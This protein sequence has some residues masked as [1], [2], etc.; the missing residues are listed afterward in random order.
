MS[1]K[2]GRG[3][4]LGRGLEGLLTVDVNDPSAEIR[5]IALRDIVRNE[6]QP[7][8][9]F[10]DDSLQ[11][12]AES[13]KEHGVLQPVLLRPFGQQFQLVAGERRWRASQLLG[14]DKIPALVREVSDREMAELS[15]IENLQRDDLNSVE[16]AMAYR[17]MLDDFGYTQETLAERLGKS[18]T[19]VS[20]TLRLLLL[21]KQVLDK[22]ADKQISASHARALLSI[23]DSTDQLRTAEA[24]AKDKIPVREV[25]LLLKKKRETRGRARRTKPELQSPELR[26]MEEELQNR[27][28]TKV[29]IWGKGVSGSIRIEYYSEED[30]ERLLELLGI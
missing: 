22:L 7:R 24:I 29:R 25:E 26:E 5:E 28:G 27:L 14:L 1:S 16:E 19:Y 3:K 23:K 2:G 9:V 8:K 10:D 17:R 6:E 21:P 11:E 4:G 15:L 20:N 13:I 12:L 30:L 18:R